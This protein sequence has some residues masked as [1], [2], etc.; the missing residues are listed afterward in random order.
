MTGAGALYVRDPAPWPLVTGIVAGFIFLLIGVI[1]L[2]H[3][4]ILHRVILPS[5]VLLGMLRSFDPGQGPAKTL[6]GGAA[7]FAILLAMYLLGLA[8]SRVISA[9]RGRPI[10]E[11]AF[12]FGDVTLGGVLGLALGWPGIVV[13]IVLG[14]FAAGVFSLLLLL[15]HLARGKYAAFLAIPYGPFLLLG[16][17]F[18]LYGGGEALRKLASG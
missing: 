17:A 13:G 4:L 11:V 15:F 12:G 14:I 2:E 3:R 7:G 16:A 1:D 10:D 9:T 18:V 6:A 8:F 5:A